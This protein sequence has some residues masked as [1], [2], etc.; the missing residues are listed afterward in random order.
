LKNSQSAEKNEKLETKYKFSKIIFYDTLG[1]IRIAIEYIGKHPFVTGLMVLLSVVGL[2]IS[3]IGFKLDRDDAKSTEEGIKCFN[4]KLHGSERDWHVMEKAFYGIRVGGPVQPAYDLK[5]ERLLRTGD[6][7]IKSI[8]WRLPNLNEFS[9]SYDSKQDRIRQIEIKWD[10]NKQGKEVGMSGF[11]FNET[12]LQDIRRSF[13]SNGFSY[14]T[15]IMYSSDDGVVTFNA[16]ELAE[17]PTIIV[18]FKTLLP[19]EDKEKIDLLPQEKQEF[20]QIGDYFRLIGVSV[21]DEAYLDD[22]WGK[23]KIYDPKCNPVTLNNG[24]LI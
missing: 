1:N 4:K 2:A 23:E 11:R 16:F 17:T 8:K 18:V 9:V 12:T 15:H 24:N 6:G 5:F 13:N 10:G 20:G 19:Y 22:V 21:A 7:V 14:A 3:I